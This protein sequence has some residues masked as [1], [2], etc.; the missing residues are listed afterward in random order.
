MLAVCF[1]ILFFMLTMAFFWISVMLGIYTIIITMSSWPLNAKIWKHIAGFGPRCH[2]YVKVFYYE[3]RT[4]L[5]SCLSLMKI[6]HYRL[7]HENDLEIILSCSNNKT[8]WQTVKFYAKLSC[9]CNSWSCKN[10]F[11][12]LN[13]KKNNDLNN[14]YE[15]IFKLY[16]HCLQFMLFYLNFI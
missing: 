15:H 2:D 14:D 8:L 4:N 13:K 6:K 16:D 3:N 10:S 11:L 7:Y 5:Y 1:C 12:R 9:L